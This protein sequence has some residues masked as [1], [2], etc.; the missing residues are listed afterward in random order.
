MLMIQIFQ[1]V[2]LMGM[3]N[4]VANHLHVRERPLRVVPDVAEFAGRLDFI[5]QRERK[6]CIDFRLK[7]LRDGAFFRKQVTVSRA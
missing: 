2:D 1:N 3:R 4:L 7:S 6:G 5:G